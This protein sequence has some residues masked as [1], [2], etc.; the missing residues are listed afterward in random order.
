MWVEALRNNMI[1]KDATNNIEFHMTK[2]APINQK[3][4]D[5]YS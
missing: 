1:S 2:P 4:R 3:K 5:L